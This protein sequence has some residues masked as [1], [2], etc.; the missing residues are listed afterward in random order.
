[1]RSKFEDKIYE[2]VYEN[3]IVFLK[4]GINRLVNEDT[5]NSDHIKH[6]LLMLTCTSFQISIELAIKALIIE[7]AGIKNILHTKHQSLS[8]IE[9]EKLFLTNKLTTR[10]FEEQKN[11]IKSKNFIEGLNRDD[12]KKITE[13]QD[14]RNK[15]VHFSYN[16]EA[17]D[18]FDLKYDLISYLIHIIFKILLS[19]KHEDIKPSAFLANKLGKDLLDGLIHYVPYVQE[20]EKLATYLSEKVFKCIDCYNRTYSQD[21]E[22]CYCCNFI[23]VDYTLINCDYCHEKESVIYDNLNIRLNNNMMRGLCLNCD[24]DSII[25]KCHKCQNAHNIEMQFEGVCTNEKCINE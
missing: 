18:F 14:Y 23:G 4:D 24:R 21:E 10:K 7:R 6:D 13:F 19:K 16:F 15:I 5:S 1:M 20:M 25:F 2:K 3:S 22:Y 17:G 8:I 11:F 12:F 9:I